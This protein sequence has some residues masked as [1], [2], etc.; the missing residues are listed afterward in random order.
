MDEYKPILAIETSQTACGTCLYF[1]KERFFE[2][3]LNI[4]NI[5][6]EKLFE[7]ID[8]V[9]NSAGIDKKDVRSIAVSSGPGSFTGLRI[10]MSAAKGIAF[11][12]SIPIIPVPSIEALAFQLAENMNDNDEFIIANRVNLE[13]VYYARFKVSAN[14][15]IFAEELKI[16][17]RDEFEKKKDSALLFGNASLNSE[18][19]TIA[20]PKPFYVAKFAEIRGK[21]LLTNNFDFLEPNYLKSFIVKE[22]KK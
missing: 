13:E 18:E 4:K 1:S 21:N 22:K 15:Y 7:L 8:S 5:H 16:I 19:K 10:G 3:E 9:V 12:L 20:S 14:N 2:A 17:E 6:A 11:G